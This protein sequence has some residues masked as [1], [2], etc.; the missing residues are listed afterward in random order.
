MFRQVISERDRRLLDHHRK[1]GKHLKIIG[2]EHIDSLRAIGLH[3]HDDLHVKY[4]SARDRM[5]L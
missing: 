4:I 2:I 1:F 3:G 5:T